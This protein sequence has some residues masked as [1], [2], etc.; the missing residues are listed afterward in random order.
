MFRR[1]FELSWPARL[2]GDAGSIRT[3]TTRHMSS[4]LPQPRLPHWSLFAAGSL[5]LPLIQAMLTDVYLTN[6]H[7][8]LSFYIFDLYSFFT[9][10]IL[11]VFLDFFT[12][13]CTKHQVLWSSNSDWM[14]P[15]LSRRQDRRTH[16]EGLTP[17]S[18]TPEGAWF[19]LKVCWSQLQRR[20]WVDQ[21]WSGSVSVHQMH[22]DVSS[23]KPTHLI[24]F[25]VLI[26][27]EEKTVTMILSSFSFLC[28]C[29]FWVSS[30][31]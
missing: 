6:L 19:S 15:R 23:L 4:F 29:V 3:R 14:S 16:S 21:G 30:V 20:V 31:L 9:Q 25:N 24:F 18:V 12:F 2:H 7:W 28:W 26:V 11:I 17:L 10:L 1:G 5:S 13:V 22:V 27:L 8:L